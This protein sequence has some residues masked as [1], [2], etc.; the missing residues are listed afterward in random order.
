MKKI[1]WLKRWEEF[2]EDNPHVY[3]LFKKYT[4]QI[5]DV[6]FANYS[7]I[8]VF[9]R[10]RWHTDIETANTCGFKINSNFT[11]YY[12][13]HFHKDYPEHDGFFRTKPLRHGV[14]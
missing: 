5:M 7:A 6:G 1:N 10:I 12:A 2:H 14:V 9:D 11:A 13:R 4:F 3:D 8:S